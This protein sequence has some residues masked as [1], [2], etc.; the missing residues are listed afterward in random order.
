MIEP[1]VQVRPAVDIVVPVY[2]ERSEALAAT[3]AACVNQTHPVSNFFIVDDGSPE[4]VRLPESMRSNPQIRLLRLPHNQGISAARN[5]ALAESTAEL[6][7]CINTEILPDPDWLSTCVEYLLQSPTVGACYTRM[8]PATPKPLLSR[9]RMRFLE[10]KFGETT[11]P[12]DFA[13]GHAVL[14]RKKAVEA[15]G[16]YDPN[17][18]V[19]Y[20]DSDICHRMRNK[21]WE[22]HY[23]ATSRC[24][25]IQQDSFPLLTKKI[26]RDTGWYSPKQGSLPHLYLHHTRMTLIRA[27]RN[28]VKGRFYFLPIDVAIW[29]YGLWTATSQTIRFAQRRSQS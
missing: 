3:L 23:I 7:A 24:V 14:F 4:P 16:G 8:V 6:V 28:A 13:P 11:Q 2:G 27:Y 19:H 15:V 25:S 12:T 20:E 1:V 10:G 26:L 9:W 17:L 29:A 18:R 5:A 21:R 22:T